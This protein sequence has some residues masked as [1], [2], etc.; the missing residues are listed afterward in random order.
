MKLLRLT[1]SSTDATFDCYL[2]QEIDLKPKAKIAL[3]SAV[4]EATDKVLTITSDN[5][6]VQFQTSNA[7]GLQT[8]ELD[9]S[10]QS[11]Y[12]SNNLTILF[13]D[14]NNKINESFSISNPE[15]IGK[16][17]EIS[18]G[19]VSGGGKVK[20]V[21]RTSAYTSSATELGLNAH[22][23]TVNGIANRDSIETNAQATV[24]PA[25]NTSN[26]N[27]AIRYNFFTHY[28][29][30]IGKG[31]ALFRAQVS[32]LSRI[33]DGAGLTQ[34]GGFSIGLS[35]STPAQS[36]A[37]GHFNDDRFT[38]LVQVL[39]E[40]AATDATYTVKFGNAAFIDTGVVVST[41]LYTSGDV[42]NDHIEIAVDRNAANQGRDL[43]ISLYRRNG[44]NTDWDRT[45]LGRTAYAAQGETPTDLYAYTFMHGAKINGGA[46]NG[47]FTCRL[48]LPRFTADPFK[49]TPTE[50]SHLEAQ[51]DYGDDLSSSAKP[52]PA[53][54]PNTNHSINFVSESLYNWLGFD[55][56]QQPTI[57]S[58]QGV[59]TFTADNLFGSKIIAD[60]FLIQLLNL[61]VEAYDTLPSKQGR[62]NILAVIPHTDEELRV[63]YEANGLYF[64]ELN[65]AS[66][67][68]LTNIRA[69]IVRQDYS[70]IQTRGL[71]SIV[72]FVNDTEMSV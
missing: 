7:T 29:H 33:V 56:G 60:A 61:P 40:T 67:I 71:S 42:K 27:N 50:T 59:A 3:Q 28:T 12:D 2:N 45:E 22:L 51:G 39:E 20:A 21:F 34:S 30:P 53:R 35:E 37:D 63:I 48:G 4:F 25:S 54:N 6:T 66:P 17:F 10:G 19:K 49:V 52:S 46:S 57:L 1:T 31:A 13:D 5:N 23:T 26:H 38:A 14:M 47:Q 8:I 11:V 9:A 72:L 58:S 70:L 41:G 55:T 43:V 36:G 32:R 15:Q 69:R 62:E 16:Q 65:N 24:G 64:I 44:G 68:K 18:D